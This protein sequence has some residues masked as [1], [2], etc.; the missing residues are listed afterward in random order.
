MAT[1][2]KQQ[3][4]KYMVRRELC[5]E[6]KEFINKVKNT[7]NDGV[8]P[9]ADHEFDNDKV[10]KIVKSLTTALNHIA[11]IDLFEL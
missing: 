7:P 8:K 3:L 4:D 1:D 2:K 5:I 9:F 10:D 6:L 11:Q